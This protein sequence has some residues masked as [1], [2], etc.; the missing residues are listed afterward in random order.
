VSKGARLREQ[1]RVQ[2]PQKRSKRPQ[3]PRPPGAGG[4]SRRTL[5]IGVIA[6]VALIAIVLVGAS[7]L[8]SRTSS[9]PKA[10]SAPSAAATN[11]L[12]AGIPQHGS[13]LGNPK[14]PVTMYEF[15]DLQCPGC[16]QYMLTTFPGIV[17]KYVRPGK[18]QV[19][20]KGISFIGPD[21]ETALRYV[22]AAGQQNKLWNAAEILYRN[23]GTENTGWV[24]NSLL[25]SVTAG[26]PGL[27]G[28]KIATAKNS[29]EINRQMA[30]NSALFTNSGFQSTPGF[31]I[32]PTG[33]TI[34]P[35]SPN[36]Y[37]VAAFSPEFA[38]ILAQHK[39]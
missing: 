29:K 33:G 6:G 27:D 18:V 13:V 11:R 38:R 5:Y 15:A 37:S 31:A 35:F 23:Q 3:T 1:R 32:G 30:A 24:T 9:N 39:Q 22:L 2:A 14:A 36:A 4:M 16:D 26:I 34:A 25:D 21:S 12:L 20:F 17:Q 7:I 28:A 19:H 8:S 10:A